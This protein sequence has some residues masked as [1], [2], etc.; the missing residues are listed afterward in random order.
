MTATARISIVGPSCATAEK[1]AVRSAQFVMPYEAFSTLHP[2]K[3]L[4]LVSKIA[5][6]FCPGVVSG[7]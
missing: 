5:E 1:I 4:P 3:I 2:E 7:N 6:G